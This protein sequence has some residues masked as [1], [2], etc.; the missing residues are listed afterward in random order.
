MTTTEILAEI[1]DR[2]GRDVLSDGKRLLGLFDDYSQGKLRPQSNALRVLIECGGNQR[3]ASLRSA[4]ALQQRTELHRL[5]QEMV[6]EYGIQEAMAREVCGAAWEAFC[7]T[8][9]PLSQISEPDVKPAPEEAKEKPKNTDQ[10]TSR[11]AASKAMDLPIPS[12]NPSPI[13]PKPKR[14]FARQLKQKNRF[15]LC[16]LAAG[17]LGAV[18]LIVIGIMGVWLS[19]TSE[20][21]RTSDMLVTLF[22]LWLGIV[23]VRRVVKVW[24]EKTGG[25]TISRWPGI[26]LFIIRIILGIILAGGAFVSIAAT[27]INT[28]FILISLLC[29]ALL[30]LLVRRLDKTDET[31]TVSRWQ[32]GYHRLTIFFYVVLSFIIIFTIVVT[33]EV[34]T[35]RGG[36]FFLAFLLNSVFNVYWHARRFAL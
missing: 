3:I 2:Q 10:P 8:E 32:E 26:L 28:G 25:K 34:P 12:E 23:T 15:V 24:Q 29:L 18:G 9:A 36:L 5:V 1:R 16:M 27:S 13:L 30:W 17:I 11:E 31:E 14:K 6:T 35:G 33:K 20:S 21:I 7:G 19:V 4:P 22:L